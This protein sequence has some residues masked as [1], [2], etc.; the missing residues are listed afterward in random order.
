M[1]ILGMT[2]SW[3]QVLVLPL[4]VANSRGLGAGLNMQTFWWII[5]IAILVMV[6]ILIPFAIFMYESDEE[7]TTVGQY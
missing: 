6:T 5:Y 3:A 2:L 1:V 7:K 4:D